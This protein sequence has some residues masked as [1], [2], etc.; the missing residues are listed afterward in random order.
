[1]PRRFVYNDEDWGR[2]TLLWTNAIIGAALAVVV[3]G[4]VFPLC[5]GYGCL[6]YLTALGVVAVTLGIAAVAILIVDAAVLIRY[7]RSRSR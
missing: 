3:L 2:R 1:M 6:I 7:L 5:S 4:F